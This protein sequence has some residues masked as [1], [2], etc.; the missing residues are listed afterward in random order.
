MARKWRWVSPKHWDRIRDLDEEQRKSYW[1][2]HH[3][4]WQRV[5][6][7][8]AEE[9]AR[10]IA[11]GEFNN[12]VIV[13]ERERKFVSILFPRI[14]HIMAKKGIDPK[15]KDKEIQVAALQT[16]PDAGYRTK[17]FKMDGE[18]NKV[19]KRKVKQLLSEPRIQNAFAVE[20]ANHGVTLEKAAHVISTIMNNVEDDPRTALAAVNVFLKYMVP[21]Q[22]VNKNLNLTANADLLYN[23]DQWSAEPPIIFTDES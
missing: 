23:P 5:R 20:M 4:I 21:T 17:P 10:K 8:R 7:E 19:A 18:P 13:R 14:L 16:L 2:R 3:I 22:T 11:S 15:V 1:L 12:L 6:K 9:K